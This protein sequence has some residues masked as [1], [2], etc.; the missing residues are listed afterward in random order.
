MIDFT[1]VI[2][3]TTKT[4]REAIVTLDEPYN[5]KK[6]A[7]VSYGARG[8]V[9]LMNGKGRLLKNVHVVGTAEESVDALRVTL[10]RKVNQGDKLSQAGSFELAG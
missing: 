1:G 5:G 10:I 8:R 2:T 9:E 6:F 4:G 3:S 7:V